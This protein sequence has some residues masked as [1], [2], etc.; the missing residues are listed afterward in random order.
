[1]R[2]IVFCISINN[3]KNKF[4]HAFLNRI[5]GNFVSVIQYINV[6]SIKKVVNFCVYNVFSNREGTLSCV[7]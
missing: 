5:R 6:F 3:V 2:K 7:Y 1:M 4:F